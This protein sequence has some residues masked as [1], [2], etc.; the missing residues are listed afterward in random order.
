MN[1]ADLLAAMAVLAAAVMLLFLLSLLRKFATGAEGMRKL[2]HVGTGLLAMPFPW[3]FSSIKPVLLVCGLA[4]ALLAVISAVPAIRARFGASLYGAGRDSHGEVYFPV[5]VVIVFALARG[6]KLLYAI[7]L[8]V[9]TLADAVAA[10]LGS[11][12]VKIP[13]EGIGGKKSVEGSV[14]FF[15]LDSWI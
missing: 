8:L 10:V 5:A 6:D 12:Y 1:G 2:A 11:I 13:Y 15:T 3:I 14:A 7:P 9:L 4:L